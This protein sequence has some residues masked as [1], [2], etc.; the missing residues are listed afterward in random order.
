MSLIIFL[1]VTPCNPRN[2]TPLTSLPGF[3]SKFRPLCPPREFYFYLTHEAYSCSFSTPNSGFHAQMYF[4]QYSLWYLKLTYLLLTR[5]QRGN[6]EAYNS[7]DPSQRQQTVAY[8]HSLQNIS[9]VSQVSLAALSA[10]PVIPNTGSPRSLISPLLPL[11][12]RFALPAPWV[13]CQMN[14]LCLFALIKIW[15]SP[16][17]W[18]CLACLELEEWNGGVNY[19]ANFWFSL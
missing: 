1:Q 11:P 7:W 2:S 9:P 8:E 4:N 19:S 5:P 18:L 15:L 17:N 10:L 12:Y 14:S 16:E 3:T 13:H 6:E